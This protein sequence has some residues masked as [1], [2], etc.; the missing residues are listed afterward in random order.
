MCLNV[1]RFPPPSSRIYYLRYS[2][3]SSE[4]NRIATLPATLPL[5]SA[6]MLCWWCTALSLISTRWSNGSCTYL[7]L[8]GGHLDMNERTSPTAQPGKD[9][10]PCLPCHSS[11]TTWFYHPDRFIKNYPIKFSQKSWGNFRW[12]THFQRPHCKNCSILQVC[13]TQHQKEQALPYTACCTTS[14]PGPC[15]F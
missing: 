1:R 7:W 3:L 5:H 4:G 10:A 9:W 8:P 2:A 13:I 14:C 6:H 15:H 12:P 11:S